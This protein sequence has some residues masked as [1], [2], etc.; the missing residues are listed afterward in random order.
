MY[1]GVGRI[2]GAPGAVNTSRKAANPAITSGRGATCR[3][4]TR[5]PCSCAYSSAVA[6]CSSRTIHAGA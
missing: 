1:A 4:G 5:Q 2:T 3:A 6:S